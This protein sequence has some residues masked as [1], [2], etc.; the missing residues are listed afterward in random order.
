M[1]VLCLF[2]TGVDR[3]EC[4]LLIG[5]KQ[6]GVEPYVICK[7]GTARI[8]ELRAA[9]VRVE[10]WNIHSKIDPTFIRRLR[11]LIRVC[12]FDLVHA[13]RKSALSNYTLASL[14]L[15]QRPVVAYRGIIGNLSYWD[16]F[17]WLTFLNP[18][19]KKLI[20]VADAVQEYFLEKRFLLFFHLFDASNVVRIYKGHR[21]EWYTR[22]PALEPI[23]PT[24]GIPEQARVIGCVSRIKA[25]KGI[26]ELIQAMA[27]LP[28]TPA[29][30]LVVVGKIEDRS[31]EKALA[32]SP[33]CDRIHL[34]GFHPDAARIAGEFDII[35]M[36]SLRR[37]GLPR[38]VIEGMAQGVV[39][40]VTDAG[41]SAELI[42]AN[43]SG[44]IVPPGDPTAL[45]DAFSRLLAD[46]ALRERM[47]MAAIQ[48]IQGHF[49]VDATVAQTLA[50][51]REILG[52]A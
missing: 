51:Y 19:L 13:F 46:D 43:V 1:K 18:R 16:P 22:D 21:V 38:A 24:L 30:H 14:G 31:Y 33:V 34:L 11:T 6:A 10:C 4:H 37:E 20:C 29:T 2:D 42:E 52:A 7:P 50:V 45:A 35:T 3:G 32:E 27:L 39:P 26:R 28:K 17:S 44:L 47:G 12:D 41:G 9:G 8:E 5:L 15:G 36:P 49:N 48:R 25:R 40:V 23:L